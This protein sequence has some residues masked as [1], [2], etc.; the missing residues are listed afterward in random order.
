M[1][2]IAAKLVI[3][4]A[5]SVLTLA[6]AGAYADPGTRGPGVNARQH[7]QKDRMRHGARSG[8]LTR[9]EAQALRQEGRDIR[10]LERE[11]KSDGALSREERRALHHELRE[12]SRNIY[13]EKHDG[14]RR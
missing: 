6:A 11:Y 14:E 3:S 8:M 12:R 9:E 13:E 5:V 10:Q 4:A 7:A 1:K 2:H